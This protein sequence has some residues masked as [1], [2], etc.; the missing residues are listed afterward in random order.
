MKAII[1][2]NNPFTKKGANYISQLNDI[3]AEDVSAMFIEAG[4]D[5]NEATKWINNQISN[6]GITIN[7]NDNLNFSAEAISDLA[8]KFNWDTTSNEYNLALSNFIDSEIQTAT[9][10]QTQL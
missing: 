8:S 5:E 2:E 9:T 4:W 7:P 1:A 10:V 3:S 6:S